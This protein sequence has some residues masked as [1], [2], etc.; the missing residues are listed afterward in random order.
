MGFPADETFYSNPPRTSPEEDNMTA[1]IQSIT[2]AGFPLQLHYID[3]DKSDDPAVGDICTGAHDD[4]FVTT[5]NGQWQLTISEALSLTQGLTAMVNHV[6]NNPWS[7]DDPSSILSRG[8][9][10]A[11]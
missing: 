9:E 11:V 7:E 8:T 2:E 3:D 4:L 1:N 6:L 5:T 10:K